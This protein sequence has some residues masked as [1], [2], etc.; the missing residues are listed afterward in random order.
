MLLHGRA[1]APQSAQPGH[2][3]DAAFLVILNQDH[4]TEF[5]VTCARRRPNLSV[6]VQHGG[7]GRRE[8]APGHPLRLEPQ[9]L[10]VL[11]AVSA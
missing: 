1:L 9:E 11:E 10:L 7:D 8:S 5:V 6:C 2:L 3:Q 4:D